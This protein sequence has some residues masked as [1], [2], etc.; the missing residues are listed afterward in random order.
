RPTALDD[1]KLIPGYIGAGP[2]EEKTQIPA[3]LPLDSITARII[4]PR[5]AKIEPYHA[6][7]PNAPP[8][9]HNELNNRIIIPINAAPLPKNLIKIFTRPE[10][11]VESDI[12]TTGEVQ[13][14]VTPANRAE[15]SRQELINR[16][17]TAV[18]YVLILLA[19]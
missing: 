16:A 12:F 17:T 1:R 15:R 6:P 5:D 13:L 9:Q 7:A 10:D 11:L 14:L 3:G 19:L 18:V 4:V 2:L 8:T